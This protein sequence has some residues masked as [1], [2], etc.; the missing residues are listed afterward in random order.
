[1]RRKPH[2]LGRTTKLTYPKHI[3]FFDTETKDNYVNTKTK[4]LTLRLGCAV[5]SICD[6]TG[7]IRERDELDFTDSDSFNYWLVTSA[8]ERQ[9]YW[10]V[11]HNIGFDIRITHTLEYLK[12]DGWTRKTFIEEGLNFIAVYAKGRT[13]IKFINNQQLFNVSLKYLGESIGEYKQR[14]DF[15]VATDRELRDYCRQ[16]VRVMQ[17]AWQV[18]IS[19]LR[20][21]NLGAFKITA[22]SQSLEAFRHRFLDHNVYIHT[23]PKAIR[24]ER[25]SYHG[26]RTDCFFIGKYDRGRVYCLDINSMYPYAMRETVP[27]KLE[28][29]YANCNIATFNRIRK[30][31]SYIATATLELTRACLP[32]VSNEG[33]LIFPTGRV[34]GTFAKPE[35]E[36]AL[37]YGKLLEV[38]EISVYDEAPIFRE[39]VDY[40]YGARQKFKAEGNPAFDYL[41]KLM[42]NSLYGKFGQRNSEYIKVGT[43]KTIPDGFYKAVTDGSGKLHKIRIL[44]GIIERETATHEGY[45]A[46]VAIASYITAR[47]RVHLD[48]LI[49]RA[50]AGQVLYCDTDSL[51]VTEQGYNNLRGDIDNITLGKLKL[52]GVEQSMTVSAPKTYLFGSKSVSKGIRS[53]AVVLAPGLYEQDQFMSFR[54]ALRTKNM[55]GVL[56]KKVVKRISSHYNKGEISNTGFVIPFHSPQFSDSL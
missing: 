56:I 21:N 7:I 22:A 49:E 29:I 55:N 36:Y 1:M 30:E 15:A 32:V 42:L 9:T 47:A 54:S 17:S 40:F 35:L 8:K 45:N 5:R 19:F 38:S 3:I 51:F 23:D 37:K 12:K 6:E 13:K 16:D 20:E 4:N 11:A 28:K 26:G 10:V 27:I 48:T 34:R 44:D 43:T 53:N 31:K 46:F 52:V 41:S 18:W 33:K 25:A 2:L 14:V 50:G 24:M 39:Y